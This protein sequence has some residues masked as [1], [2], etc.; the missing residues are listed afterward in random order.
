[1]VE[2]LHARLSARARAAH[3][4][5]MIGVAFDL[6]GLFRLDALLCPVDRA[7]RFAG[8]HAHVDAAP[9]RTLLAERANPPLHA[10]NELFFGDQERD[11]LLRLAAAIKNDPRCPGDA[12]S[13]E[14]ISALHL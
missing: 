6:F 9:G 4:D 14:K 12:A 10:R 7:D 3:A 5:R 1:M 11:Q 8:H 13:L 2:R